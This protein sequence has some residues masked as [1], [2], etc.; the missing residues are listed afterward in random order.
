MNSSNFSESGNQSGS[1]G[2]F[3]SYSAITTSVKQGIY[4]SIALVAL[5][6]NTVLCLSILQQRR[7]TLRKPYTTII[8]TLAFTDIFT[9]VFLFLS[10]RFV[11]R[12]TFP[13]PT[14]AILL[15]VYCHLLWARTPLFFFGVASLYLCLLLTLER[16]IAVTHPSKHHDVGSRRNAIRGVVASY[17]ISLLAM[18]SSVPRIDVYPDRPTGQ[19]CSFGRVNPSRFKITGSIAFLVK[20]AIPCTVIVALYVHMAYKLRRTSMVTQRHGAKLRKK[21]TKVAAIVSLLL[22]ICWTPNQVTI[23]T[24]T[25]HGQWFEPKS[26]SCLSSVIVRVT[27]RSALS[28]FSSALSFP[29]HHFVFIRPPCLFLGWGGG[30]GGGGG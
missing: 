3:G 8:L 26:I 23:S 4:W 27:R 15:E 10:P 17:C 18:L 12:D 6:G 30:G 28:F 9:A 2:Y 19:R 24:F 5:I 16:W 25:V 29:Q 13:Q 7:S 11:F 20:S 22:I 21:I 14:N 1:T